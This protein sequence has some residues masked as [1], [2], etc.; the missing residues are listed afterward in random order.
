MASVSTRLSATASDCRNAPTCTKQT[1][2]D[3]LRR[4]D[5]HGVE[6]TQL[7]RRA[8]A[9]RECAIAAL[10]VRFG[11]WQSGDGASANAALD[12]ALADA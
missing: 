5:L 1:Q 2:P 12:Y 11:R 8:K 7:P 6:K 9:A 4:T 3:R 10:P